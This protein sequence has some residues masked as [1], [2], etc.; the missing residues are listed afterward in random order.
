MTGPLISTPGNAAAVFI[1]SL[2]D[3]ICYYVSTPRRRAGDS[4]PTTELF[5]DSPATIAAQLELESQAH[6]YRTHAARVVDPAELRDAEASMALSPQAA[7]VTARGA[8]PQRRVILSH[9]K[10]YF[11]AS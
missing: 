9:Q 10:M 3:S 1:A 2:L 6:L 5:R 4:Q 7:L 11:S 8:D